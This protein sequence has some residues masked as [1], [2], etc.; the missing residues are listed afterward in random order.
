[1]DNIKA[2]VISEHKGAYK[3]INENGEFLAKVTGK[4]MFT[5]K[6]REDYPAIGDFVIIDELPEN[7]AVI[8][9]ILPR[10]SIIK[11]KYGDKNKS[12]EKS[13]TQIIAVNID[14]AFIVQSLGRDYNLNRFERY[15]SILSDGSIKPA[16]ILNKIDLVSKQELDEVLSQIKNRFPNV[17][18]I[19][20]STITDKDLSGLKNYLQVGKTYCFLG[21]SGVGKSSIINKLLGNPPAGGLIK[22]EQI[23]SYSDRGK[24]ITTTRQMYFLESGAIVIDNPGIRE[25]GLTDADATLE[26]LFDKITELSLQCKFNDCTHTQEIG[27]NVLKAVKVGEIDKK[28]FENYLNLKKEAEFYK[29]SEIEKKEKERDFGKFIKKAKKDLKDY[30]IKN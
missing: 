5:A 26:S 7:N 19:L 17:D 15:F 18:V 16:I 6:S 22:T 20:T 30:S 14:I 2:R 23:S 10:Q 28:Q 11:R 25:V 1:M 8:K 12:G 27:C 24:H 21:S 29:M 3:V 9:S 13:D 4:Q